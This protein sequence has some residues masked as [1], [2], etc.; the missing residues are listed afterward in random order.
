MIGRDKLQ[1]LY[2][3]VKLAK[4]DE[5]ISLMSLTGSLFIWVGLARQDCTA[6]LKIFC[7][8]GKNFAAYTY[9]N[10][11]LCPSW[12]HDVFYVRRTSLDKIKDRLPEREHK[13]A[14][15][16][17]CRRFYMLEPKEEG[18]FSND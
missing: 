12:L 1:A 14:T 5:N 9:G 2:N 15:T 16:R 6:F 7:E 4:P 10:R 3:Y 18:L 13:Q 8:D 11:P 17:L